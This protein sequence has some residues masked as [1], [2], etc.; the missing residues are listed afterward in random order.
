[1]RNRRKHKQVRRRSEARTLTQQ[2][3]E[4]GWVALN[5]ECHA[6]VFLSKLVAAIPQDAIEQCPR[7]GLL[8]VKIEAARKLRG[9]SR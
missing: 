4:R 9:A 5:C 1:M 8:G 7:T 3:Y 6:Y 2:E